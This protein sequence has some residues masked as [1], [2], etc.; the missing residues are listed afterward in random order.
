MSSQ[1]QEFTTA[2]NLPPSSSDL[3]PVDFSLLGAL[4]Q[5]LYHQQ[6]RGID[7]WKHVLLHWWIQ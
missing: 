2:E 4:Q 1:I 5:K 6:I 3:I 7:Y